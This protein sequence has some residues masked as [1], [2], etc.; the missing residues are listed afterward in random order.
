MRESLAS[1]PV[2]VLSNGPEPESKSCLRGSLRPEPPFGD[3]QKDR[4]CEAV[5]RELGRLSQTTSRSCSF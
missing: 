4:V 5:I 3:C 1:H 2:Q